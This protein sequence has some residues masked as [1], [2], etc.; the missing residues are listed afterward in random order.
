MKMSSSRYEYRVDPSVEGFHIMMRNAT[1][2]AA[3]DTVGSPLQTVEAA[4]NMIEIYIA[5]D[6]SEKMLCQ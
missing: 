2:C 3:W 6:E 5:I 4:N 1:P